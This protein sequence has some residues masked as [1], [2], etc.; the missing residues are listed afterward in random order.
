MEN[1]R[2]YTAPT[3]T[4]INFADQVATDNSNILQLPE[5]RT[6]SVSRWITGS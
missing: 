5:V 4:V 1:K 2:I 6:N 3:A